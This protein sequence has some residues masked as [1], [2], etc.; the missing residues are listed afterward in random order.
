MHIIINKCLSLIEIRR[1]SNVW[2][3]THSVKWGQKGKGK[4]PHRA[5]REG[6]LSCGTQKRAEKRRER[7]VEIILPRCSVRTY[8]SGLVDD[9]KIQVG[10]A[11]CEFV[12]ILSSLNIYHFDFLYQFCPLILFKTKF[13]II[14]FLTII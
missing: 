4:C 12:I 14:I 11:Q 8:W 2:P 7:E 5:A 6:Y 1:E 9:Q 10:C 3:T 13:I